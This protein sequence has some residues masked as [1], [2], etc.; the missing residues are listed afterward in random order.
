[1][2]FYSTLGL[3]INDLKSLTFN[4]NDSDIDPKYVIDSPLSDDLLIN[5]NIVK[6]SFEQRYHRIDGDDVL[7]WIGF[8]PTYQ[9]KYN[10]FQSDKEQT[11][12]SGHTEDMSME[13]DE[14]YKREFR[15]YYQQPFIWVDKLWKIAKEKVEELSGYQFILDG[16]W[17]TQSNPYYANLIYT[18]PSLFTSDDSFKEI[19]ENF[20][21]TLNV[22]AFNK[23]SKSPKLSVHQDYLLSNLESLNDAGIYDPET[24]TFN[25]NL[26]GS[27]NLK[28]RFKCTLFASIPG[29]PMDGYWYCKILDDNP[30]YVK[31]KA[32]NA[33]TGEE[34]FAANKT[35]LLYSDDYDVNSNSFDEGIDLGVCNI[36]H[37]GVANGVRPLINHTG[38]Q[39]GRNHAWECY[40]DFNLNVTE[41]VPYKVYFEVWN[42]NNGDPFEYTST[43]DG[44]LWDL[45]WADDFNTSYGADN[46]KGYSMYF[47]TENVSCQSIENLRSGSSLSLYRIFP[48]D[49][50]LCDVLL[51]Y[52]KM[53][54]L[55]WDVDDSNKTITVMTRNRFFEDYRILDWTERIDR[56]KE[57]KAAP[58]TFDKK[59]VEF[60]FNEGKCGRLENYQST[61]QSNYGNKKLDTGYE[62]NSET[63]NLFENLTPSV[64][65]QKRQY[66]KMMNTEYD[67]R[68]EFMGYSYMVY[69]DERYV[70]NDS[71]GSNAGM[72]GAFYFRNGCF[73]PDSRLSNWDTDGKYIVIVTDD[74]EHMI[75]TQEYCWNSSGEG[76]A[77]CHALPDVST[78]SNKSRGERYSVHFESPKEY[79]FTTPDGDVNYIYHS[80]WENYINERYC[81]QNKKLTAYVYIDIDEFKDIDFREFIKID[82]ILYHIDKIYDFNYNA[83]TPVKMDLVQVWDLSA[84][85]E[86]QK[87][88]PYLFTVPQSVNVTTA[89]QTV[90]VYTSYDNW[91]IASQPSWI[92]AS[93]D[94]NGDLVVSATETT[95]QYRN[96]YIALVGGATPVAGELKGA[97]IVDVNQYPTNEYRLEVDRN[98]LLFTGDGGTATVVVD[99]HNKSNGAIVV[100]IPSA[101]RKWLKANIAEYNRTA[102]TRRDCLHLVVTVEPRTATTPRNGTVT[103]SIAAG[104]T[105]YTQTINIGQQGGSTHSRDDN[106]SVITDG[107]S[108][109]VVRDLSDNPVT[110]LVSGQ[111]YHFTDLFPEE[112]DANSIRIS[113][114]GS[115][116]ITGNSGLQ[117]IE[118]IPQLSDNDQVGG[119]MITVTTMNGNIVSYAYDVEVEGYVPPAPPTPPAPEPTMEQTYFFI[120]DASGNGST[121]TVALRNDYEEHLY[122]S[123]N[124]TDWVDLGKLSREPLTADVPAQKRLYFKSDRSRWYNTSTSTFKVSD[125]YNVGGNIMSLLYMDD[126]IGRYTFPTNE[127]YIFGYMFYGESNLMNANDLV[128]PATTLNQLC[129]SDMFEGCTSLA[130]T[131]ALP[132][133]TLVDGCYIRM[134]EGCTSLATAPELPATT[135]DYRCYIRMFYG[136]SSLATAPALPAT[137]LANSCYSDMF[138]GCTSLATAPALPATTLTR[139]CYQYM[140]QGC[141]SLTSAPAL[142]ATKLTRYC[143]Y[144][145]FNSCSNLKTVTTYAEDISAGG[146]LDLWLADVASEGEFYNLGGATYTVDSPSGI[147]QGWTEYTDEPI[148]PT[149]TKRHVVVKSDEYSMF[150]IS[151]SPSVMS[152]KTANYFEDDFV[153]GTVITLTAEPNEGY[154]LSRWVDQNDVVYKTPVVTFTVNSDLEIKLESKVAKKTFT[155]NLEAGD[156]YFTIGSDSTRYTTLHR[157]VA[158]GSVIANVK[159][160]S[161]SQVTR[162]FKNWSDGSVSNP[163]DFT[164]NKDIDLSVVYGGSAVSYATIT[165]DGGGLLGGDDYVVL[166]LNTTEQIRCGIGE[167]KSVTVREASYILELECHINDTKSQFSYFDIAGT[168]YQGQNPFKIRDYSLT[169]DIY[170]KVGC[171][172]AVAS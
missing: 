119:G 137:T 156:G 40:L 147:P 86:G 150:K 84:Y 131:P 98:T 142:P 61:Y 71:E 26:I 47:D 159:V 49:V 58:L 158:E 105:V 168:Q 152:T 118:F 82:N 162:P 139:N 96:G 12:P 32:V 72:Y 20:A 35:F 138:E 2:T 77:V 160:T 155:L 81:S 70:D 76:W 132:A 56:S 15:S 90:P 21:D 37:T 14:H 165:L 130:T 42:A 66:S 3:V 30:F 83:N 85:T 143:Y 153:D 106:H 79:Y 1:M 149:P 121:V 97:W 171:T 17:F 133:T 13:R 146:C 52:S 170:I 54:G 46:D 87:E 4:K 48:K 94:G 9:G 100:T 107:D 89:Q 123:E 103:L 113:G 38:Y 24:S 65:C 55:S 23:P 136:C 63:N 122:C 73:A 91:S 125:R 31:I 41:N 128:L 8:I 95:S 88:I 164:V 53:F 64:V 145:M 92:N 144:N 51:N 74:T 126:F 18:C 101:N 57:F 33:N 6:D 127:S 60:N 151:A 166:K 167:V 34:I 172:P 22:T 115:V 59:Y 11:L 108:G 62:F 112:V 78:I 39:N 154:T 116:N 99:C 104:G 114:G 134:F 135:L 129:Y 163:R 169:D 148:T 36:T 7:D 157:V 124:Q 141:S 5:R 102:T 50:T 28:G 69:P 29:I 16:S 120:E 19:N 45:L 110:S 140:F 67:D 117:T 68:P 44:I 25:S 75:Q 161:N 109:V 10:D 111:T 93:A 80:F 43:F 27:T